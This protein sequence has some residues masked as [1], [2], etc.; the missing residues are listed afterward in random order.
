M[1]VISPTDLRNEQRKYLELAETEKVVVKRGSKLIHLVVSDRLI[2]D[3]DLKRGISCQ[4][5]KKR[6]FKHID[7]L[8]EGKNECNSRK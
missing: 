7:T 6:V 2:T 3:E 8:F 1:I 5:A 4:E